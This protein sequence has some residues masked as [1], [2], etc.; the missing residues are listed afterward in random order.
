MTG[1]DEEQVLSVIR[2]AP[3]THPL[4]LVTLSPADYATLRKKLSRVPG[5]QMH[6][7]P[8]P[9]VRDRRRRRDRHGRY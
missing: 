2:A 7:V 3:Q 6:R 9:P 8:A 1:L 4:T 5:L